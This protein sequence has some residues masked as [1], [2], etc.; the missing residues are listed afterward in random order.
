MPSWKG[1]LRSLFG[2]GSE[3]PPPE[4]APPQPS[5]TERAR[6]LAADASPFGVPVLDLISVTG[7]YLSA[8]R[9][10]EIA[11]RAISWRSSSGDELDV[12]PLAGVPERRVDLRY[13]CDPLLRD[14]L[15]F[16]PSEMEHKWVLALRG[17]D[18]LIA[19]SWLGDVAVLARGRRVGGELIIDELRVRTDAQLDR[20]GE[21]VP[22][23]DWLIRSHAL[24]Q[25]L[26]L[27][28]HAAGAAELEADPL[29]AMSMFGHMARCA[30]TSWD[31][32]APAQPLRTDSRLMQ[33]VRFEDPVRVRELAA[34]G[35]PLDS[36]SP[37]Q[38][39]RPLATAAIKND[40]TMLAL[41]LE[42]GADPNL[43][44]DRGLVPLGRV[45]VHGGDEAML[46]MLVAAGARTDVV[47]C[48]GFGLLHAVAETNRAELIPW[49]LA[50]G[51]G[52][53]T[54]TRHD[55]TPLHIACALGHVETAAALLD[56][57]ADP[58]AEAKAK[59]ARTIAIEND[60]AAIV[61]LLDRRSSEV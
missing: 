21:L 10:P 9:D 15:L 59:D 34:A 41:L 53:E 29:I 3:P 57:G 19:R 58:H 13:P 22:T 37:T 32:P 60:R 16:C 8:S 61:E 17:D 40:P 26:P 20:C 7:N 48:D 24:R 6:W 35:E 28:V 5:S 42:L 36:P 44:D 45:I 43:G 27:P 52:L 56:V 31:P 39:F 51:V 25:N 12:T 11:Q 50:H 30:A 55:H 23:I 33:A 54:R 49:M 46:D 4:S 18:I 1:R 38:G 47:N 2:Q 14:G